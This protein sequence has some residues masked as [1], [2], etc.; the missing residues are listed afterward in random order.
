MSCVDHANTLRIIIGYVVE[1][2]ATL[3]VL[4]IDFKQA[5]NSVD[6]AAIWR[7]IARNRV[8][9][10]IISIIKSMYDDVNLATLPNRQTSAPF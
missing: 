9:S 10:N 6:K 5:F 7:V 4:F 1:W 8:P 2:I 3:Y